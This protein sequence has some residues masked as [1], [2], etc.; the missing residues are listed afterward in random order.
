[1]A[2]PVRCFVTDFHGVAQACQRSLVRAAALY[3]L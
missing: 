1:M 2:V 3:R